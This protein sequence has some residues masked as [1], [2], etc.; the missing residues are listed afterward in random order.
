LFT[1]TFTAADVVEFPAASR[2]IARSVC[3]PF[4]AVV[5]FQLTVKGA[6]VSAAPRFEPSSVNWTLAT[7]TLSEAVAFTFTGPDTVAPFAGADTDTAGGVVSDGP[8]RL[9]TIAWVMPRIVPLEL[10]T[11][12]RTYVADPDR[13]IVL[14]AE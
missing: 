2:A 8:V 10:L 11:S 5:V 1:V 9:K 13:G 3:G 14:V 6:D 12:A 7:P 4:V